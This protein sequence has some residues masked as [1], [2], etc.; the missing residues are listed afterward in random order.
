MKHL[1]RAGVL[2]SA[3]LLFVFVGL[4]VMPIPPFLT[5]FGFH[6][7]NVEE[8][9]ALWASLP[10]QY[11]SSSI[12]S[13]CHQNE[14]SLR[15]KAKHRSVSCETCHGPA[16]EHLATG[17]AETLDTSRELCGLCHARLISRPSGFPQVDMGKMGGDA[18]CITCHDPHEPR[19]GM[20]PEV[21]HHLEERSDC[22][23]C[24]SPSEP[25]EIPPPQTPHTLEG[26]TD[27]LSCHGPSEIRGATLPHIPSSVAGITDC[28]ACHS[29][30]GGIKPLPQDHLGRKSTTCL[31]CH[32]SE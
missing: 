14:Y 17:A 16:R 10:F 13:D 30:G 31:N 32:R 5:G 22:Q 2:L 6:Q 18:E 8:N 21:P 7:K 15:E 24:H 20:P 29:V 11:V 26:R 23:T 28:L 25:L 27:C 1:A 12:C 4:R 9:E 3:V 19:V